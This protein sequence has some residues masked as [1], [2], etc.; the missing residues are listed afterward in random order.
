M[1]LQ[2]QK[3]T[4][5]SPQIIESIE[6]QKE[7]VDILETEL[8]DLRNILSPILRSTGAGSENNDKKDFQEKDK[9]ELA[10]SI[11]ETTIRIDKIIDFVKSI[12]NLCEL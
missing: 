1:E 4:P 3:D 5:R 8:N 9:V 2:S 12:N 6:Y 11:D 7:R 10:R